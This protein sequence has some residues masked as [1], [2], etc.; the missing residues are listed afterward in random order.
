MAER[1]NKWQKLAE[2]IE[3]AEKAEVNQEAPENESEV[4]EKNDEA[5]K[6]AVDEQKT[7]SLDFPS[8]RDLENQL[9]AMEMKTSEL[10]DKLARNQAELENVRR[11]TEREIRDA[12][13]YG[14]K[15]FAVDL[16][17]VV[18]SIM[19][20]IDGVE[21]AEPQA[22]SIH[23]GMQLTLD[24]FIKTLKKHGIEIISP[25]K[26]EAFDPSLHEAVSIQADPEAKS[27]TIL[28]VVQEGFSLNGRVLRAAI[29]VVAQ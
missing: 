26:G 18:D 9:T 28:E 12:H 29:V 2:E 21:P 3:A 24:M 4:V 25:E 22:K 16:L 11:R 19:R 7:E 8:R 14:I 27:N 10:K 20:G 6:E 17:P 23:E 5:S 13:K 15:Q 1:V